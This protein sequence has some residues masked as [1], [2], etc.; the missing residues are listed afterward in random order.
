[1]VVMLA[2]P[3]TG[4]LLNNAM[5]SQSKEGTVKVC[6]NRRLRGSWPG[7]TVPSMASD[8]Q[9]LKAFLV[10]LEGRIAALDAELAPL[11]SGK[12]R[13]GRNGSDTEFRWVDIS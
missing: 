13:I 11:E 12:T 4:H 7:V 6:Q 3:L 2:G 8:P 1:I 9:T 5:R 10:Y